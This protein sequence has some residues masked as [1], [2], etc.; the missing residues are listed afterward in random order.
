MKKICLLALVCLIG[1]FMCNTSQAAQCPL[2]GANFHYKT[3]QGYSKNSLNI[4]QK[5]TIENISNREV[6]LNI[7]HFIFR[8]AGFNTVK[9]GH[10][11]GGFSSTVKNPLT[12]NLVIHFIQVTSSQ[13]LLTIVLMT[14]TQLVGN[15]AIAIMEIW[16]FSQK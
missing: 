5:F 3:W 15:C 4:R 13:F 10:L 6:F 12:L 1:V 14:L 2:R 16:L 11:G 7:D 8:K 9:P